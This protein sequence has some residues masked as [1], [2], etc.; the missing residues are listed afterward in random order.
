MSAL[1]PY[2][3]PETGV[4][5]A[6]L[7]AATALE[8]LDRLDCVMWLL[9]AFRAAALADYKEGADGV[10]L[11]G[12]SPRGSTAINGMM[13]YSV[14]SGRRGMVTLTCKMLCVQDE[15]V[16]IGRALV[17]PTAIM[18]KASRVVTKVHKKKKAHSD[19]WCSLGFE[20]S[21]PD[22]NAELTVDSVAIAAQGSWMA[23][24]PPPPPSAA[25]AVASAAAEKKKRARPQKTA[26]G[27]APP[28]PPPP[29]SA[30]LVVTAPPIKK[31][32]GRPSDAE[33]EAR[34]AAAAAAAAIGETSGGPV[35]GEHGEYGGQPHS[36][37]PGSAEVPMGGAAGE[38]ALIGVA[39]EPE[40]LTDIYIRKSCPRRDFPHLIRVPHGGLPH[41]G[42]ETWQLVEDEELERSQKVECQ[43]CGRVLLLT[44]EEA[45]VVEDAD[46]V[47]EQKNGAIDDPLFE[48]TTC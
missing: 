12:S 10:F 46:W 20:L 38:H 27:P 16:A 33:R 35:Y 21:S 2:V 14:E 39:D 11:S 25:P 1:A 8:L 36:M 6:P 18:H 19:Y 28:P 32:R 9:P 13:L 22:D 4:T 44:R 47:C 17:V 48:D 42:E 23:A 34:A 29:P 45:E 37:P 7:D 26:R 24:A 43:A 41:G 15:S 5:V 30:A 31:K 40:E 3:D